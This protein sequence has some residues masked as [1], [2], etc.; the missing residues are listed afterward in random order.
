VP[1]AVEVPEPVIAH[2]ETP[3]PFT[4][5]GAKGIGEGNN[6]STP[7]CIANAI[8][9]AL[10]PDVD[11]EAI[12]LPM[13][14]SRMVELLAPPETPPQTLPP[15]P[16]VAGKQFSASGSVNIAAPPEAIYHVLHDPAKMKKVIPGCNNVEAVAFNAYRADMSLS[17][18]MVKARFRVDM[19]L[20]DEDPMRRIRLSGKGVGALGSAEGDG[21]ITLNKTEEGTRLDYDYAFSLSGKIVSVGARMVESA[22]TMVLRQLFVRLG[23]VASGAAPAKNL[24]QRLLR[25]IGRNE[26]GEA[27]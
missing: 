25:L 17:V 11:P 27:E 5:L 10:G 21:R 1:T 22:A 16:T 6:M 4:P 9:D 18:G 7:V 20:A 2:M 19:R 12:V 24:R 26:P 14:P 13:T 15:A 8:A 23:R 3:S